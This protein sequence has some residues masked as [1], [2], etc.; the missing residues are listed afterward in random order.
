MDMN[1]NLGRQFREARRRRGLAQRE[2]A[3]L[4]RTSQSAVSR[5]ESAA[6]AG[7]LV[8]LRRAASALKCDLRIELLDKTTRTAPEGGQRARR[9]L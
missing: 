2:L 9:S 6:G 3:M 1:N 7:S 5:L 8:T 4:M